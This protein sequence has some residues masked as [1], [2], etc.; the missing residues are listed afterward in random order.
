MRT[1]AVSSTSSAITRRRD[2]RIENPTS[3][4]TYQH[5]RAK[6]SIITSFMFGPLSG[7]C[8]EKDR[9]A[10]L[11]IAAR[12]YFAPIGPLIDLGG[13][14]LTAILQ[15]A[16]TRMWG[17]P[18]NAQLCRRLI[19]LTSRA[20]ASIC[21]IAINF[22]TN[23]SERN[24]RHITSK[25]EEDAVIQREPPPALSTRSRNRARIDSL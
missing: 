15:R 22:T 12:F 18:V 3:A 21:Y 11:T 5:A 19:N 25:S 4:V 24:K 6:S 8:D 14:K 17:W 16:S 9:I 13:R 23:S 1:T 20:S 2:Q 7:C 10:S